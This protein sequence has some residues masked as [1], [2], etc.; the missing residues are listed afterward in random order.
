MQKI[1]K[2]LLK[3]ISDIDKPLKG[4][5][6]IRKNGKSIERQDSQNIKIVSKENLADLKIASSATNLTNEPPFSLILSVSN[7]P[8]GLPPFSNDILYAL[9]FLKTVASNCLDKALTTDAPTP[10]KPPDVL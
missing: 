4:A 7:L 9:L 2:I 5:Y 3:Q 10:C 1:D 6:N 8:F